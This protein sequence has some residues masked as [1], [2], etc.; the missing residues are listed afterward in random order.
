MYCACADNPGIHRFLYSLKATRNDNRSSSTMFGYLEIL[1]LVFIKG[2]SYLRLEFIRHRRHSHT[3]FHTVSIQCTDNGRDVRLV[4]GTTLHEGRLEVCVN[5]SWITVCDENWKYRNVRVVCRQLGYREEGKDSE[6]IYRL[7]KLAI[8]K[9]FC[10]LLIAGRAIYGSYFGQGA[11]LTVLYN[12]TCLGNETKLLNCPHLGL[13]VGNCSVNHNRDISVRCVLREDQ[14][15]KN[16][17]LSVDIINISSTVHTAL[18]S[19]VLHNT[20]MDEPNSFDVTCFDESKQHSV[21][22]SVSGQNFTTYLVGLLPLTSYNCCVSAVYEL[23]VADEVCK[24]IETPE[25][26]VRSTTTEILRSSTNSRTSE[27][28]N[29]IVGGVLGFII[30][31]LLILLTISG[32]ALVYLSQSR[33]KESVKLAR[34]KMFQ[35][36]IHNWGGKLYNYYGRLVSMRMQ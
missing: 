1:I 22:M 16:I 3:F 5:S 8:L 33:R 4:D 18:I 34:Y 12:V 23:Y 17:T 10:A 30:M 32:V 26:F 31:I 13:P 9:L 21:A 2:K 25:L 15:V 36:L 6:S 29:V 11:G 19:W 24:E 14:R 28:N 35:T 20:T 27:S 7:N